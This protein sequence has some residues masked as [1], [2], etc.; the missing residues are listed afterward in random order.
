M[1]HGLPQRGGQSKA[2]CGTSMNE[3][4]RPRCRR[5]R[6]AAFGSPSRYSPIVRIPLAVNSWTQRAVQSCNEPNAVSG[7]GTVNGM[8]P[9]ESFDLISTQM[10][11]VRPQLSG[12]PP[13]FFRLQAIDQTVCARSRGESVES[14]PLTSPR[15]AAAIA[16]R[17][18]TIDQYHAAQNGHSN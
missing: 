7:P 5:S 15:S 14:H 17:P 8:L 18:D 3:R 11:G 6:A 16:V 13:V 1:D 2:D 9:P 4:S 12:D 10:S